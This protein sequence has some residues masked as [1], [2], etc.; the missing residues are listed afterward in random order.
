MIVDLHNHTIASHDGF[1]NNEQ[2]LNACIRRSVN[3]I[4]V[5]EHDRACSVD[6]AKFNANGIELIPGCEYTT[7]G[8]AHI[9]GLFVTQSLQIG[10][11]RETILN[12]I[13]SNDGIAVM[14]HPFK[15]VSGYLAIH[16]DEDLVSEFDFIELINGGWRTSDFRDRIIDISCRRNLVMISSSDSHRANQVG[17]CVTKICGIQNFKVGD[18]KSILRNVQQ[19]EIEMMIDRRI[20]ARKERRIKKFQKLKIYQILLHFVPNKVRRILKLIQYRYSHDLISSPPNFEVIET[21]N[22]KW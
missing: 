12:F 2:L 16:G 3:A 14:P 20:L 18:A 9:I 19:S 11:K 13:K 4:A 21:R 7:E 1:T 22:L 17:M 10:S 8:G 15:P 5:T 6:R